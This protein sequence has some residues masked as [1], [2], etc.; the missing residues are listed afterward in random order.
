MM[1]SRS[2]TRVLAQR[3]GI[4]FGIS[5]VLMVLAVVA[6]NYVINDKISN[7]ARIK[8]HTAKPPPQGAN[9]LLIGSDTRAFVKNVGEQQAFGSAQDTGG[10]RSDTM[11]ILHV[12]PGARHTLV[13][14]FPRDLWVNIPGVGMSKINGAFNYG[15]DKVIET[16]KANFGVEI[17]HFIEVDFKSFQGVVRAVGSVPTYFPYP[18][19][20]LKT[21][22]FVRETGCV[23]LDGPASLSYVRSRELEYLNVNTHKWIAADAIPDIS[24]IARQQSFIRS[25]AGLAVA[26]SLNDPLTANEIADRVVE[27]LKVDQG[28]TKDEIL[29]LV[30][31]FRTIN[32]N[33]S[34]A[35]DMRT[36]PWSPGPKQSG[37]DVLYPKEPDWHASV[38]LLKD[39]SGRAAPATV[40]PSSTK[41]RVR[42]ASGL[43]GAAT[44]ALDELAKLG[45]QRGGSGNDARGTIAAT[46]VRYRPGAIDAGKL[47]LSYI[48]PD[49]RLVA[50]PAI[51]G[52]DVV[53][54][55]GTD[56]AA[57]VKP[58]T[59]ATSSPGAPGATLDGGGG[60]GL[61]PPPIAGASQLGSAAPKNPPC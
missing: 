51:T 1:P 38:A 29:T 53:V 57:I 50:D 21:N 5:A 20:D 39:F 37:Q 12:E 8:V 58:P 14:S 41:V 18:A 19:R 56:F 25:M 40:R 43:G 22:L 35:L 59:A 27:N 44:G 11:M 23:R 13:M 36:L 42:N 2:T 28:L 60:G 52:V 55:L 24:R 7:I 45:F 33:D 47:V 6:V 3:Y 54:V 26:K 17:N 34:S 10:Q 31:A 15:P 61:T 9:Y 4:A 49:A 32:P 48:Q 16:L 30:D 46:E